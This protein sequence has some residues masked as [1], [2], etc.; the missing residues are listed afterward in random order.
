MSQ[1]HDRGFI[2][3]ASVNKK[4]L[5]SACLS[6]GSLR[7]HYPTANITLFTT[8]DLIDDTFDISAFDNVITDGVPKDR[9]AKLWALSRTPYKTTAYLDADTLITSEEISTIF[10]QLGDN[11]IIFT[12]IRP[13]NSN[14]KGYLD[15]PGYVYHGGVFVYNDLPAMDEFMN[16]WWVLWS[17]T[18]FKDVFA[19]TYPQFPDRM[20]EWD[21]FYLY[22]LINHTEHNL[23]IGFFEN[24]A[25]WNFVAGYR[26]SELNGLSTIIEH[27]TLK[28]L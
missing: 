9:R 23:K 24:D 10:D 26:K 1:R 4:Y 16:Q 5:S 17:T 14:P 7:E 27:Y 6:A 11:D 2:Y 20:K 13:Y 28:L 18:R 25:R 8:D 22:Y 21:Q 12:K 3:V 19:T 15:D